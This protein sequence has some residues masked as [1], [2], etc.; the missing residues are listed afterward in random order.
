MIAV[1]TCEFLRLAAPVPFAGFCE[2]ETPV[3]AL[4]IGPP[5]NVRSPAGAP[6]AAL[7]GGALAH[8]FHAWRGASGRRHIFSVFSAGDCPD[9]DDAVFLAVSAHPLGSRRIL[10]I[11]CDA[12]AAARLCRDNRGDNWSAEIHVHLLAETPASRAAV[13]ADLAAALS[14]AAPPARRAS[15][16]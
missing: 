3:W 9:Y 10:G 6:L 1:R 4:P 14:R 7:A 8:R 16:L 12:G 13:T 15:R 2:D 5:G 11:S